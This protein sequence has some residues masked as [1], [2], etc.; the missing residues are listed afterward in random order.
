MNENALKELAQKLHLANGAVAVL[1]GAGM[2]ME[3]G[4][5]DFRSKDGWWRGIDP[6]TVATADALER[7][8]E[9]FRE[10]YRFR[11]ET[12]ERY[13]PHE[14]HRILA[15]WERGGTIR[16][17]ATQNVDGFHAMAGSRSI[18]ELHGSIR[19]AR[20]QRCGQEATT[21]SFVGGQSCAG[22]QGKLRPNV[23]LFGEPLPERAWNQALAWIREAELVLVIGTSLQVAPAN[24]LPRLTSGCKAY[25]GLEPADGSYGFDISIQ[26][27]AG[28]TLAALDALARELAP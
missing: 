3:S 8:Y 5:P 22:C 17:I 10:F 14:G 15:D 11:I 13:A 4:L 19:T 18:A 16:G 1:T 23:V 7:N 9:L 21:A 12:A 2:S 27:K 25:I 20:C 24:Q 28:E 26:G 6:M